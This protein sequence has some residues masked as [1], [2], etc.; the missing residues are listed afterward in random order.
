MTLKLNGK[1]YTAKTNSKG[2]AKFSVKKSDIGKL[3]A[4][5]KYT[6]RITYLK[7]TLKRTLKVKR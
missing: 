5:K 2:V 1:K 7:D 3:K 4:G 6:M